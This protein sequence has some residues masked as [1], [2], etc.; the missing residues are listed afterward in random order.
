MNA[1]R[2]TT[3]VLMLGSLVALACGPKSETVGDLGGLVSGQPGTNLYTTADPGE[4]TPLERPYE[5]APPLVPH[6]VA[7]LE[8]TRKSNDCID[9]HLDGEEL[10]EGHVATKIPPSHFVNTYTGEQS[11]GSVVGRRYQCLQCHVPQTSA[12]F[13]PGAR[14]GAM[15][16]SGN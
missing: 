16:G 1:L 4:S 10:E 11:K 14:E 5:I 12:S 3:T 15:D 13:P 8:I 2:R 9:C 7:G 6:S